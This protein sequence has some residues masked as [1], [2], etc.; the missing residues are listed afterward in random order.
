MP[1]LGDLNGQ[2]L[3]G[4]AGVGEVPHGLAYLPYL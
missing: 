3:Y 1:L 2:A 4:T